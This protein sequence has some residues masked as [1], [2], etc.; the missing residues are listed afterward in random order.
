MQKNF[1]AAFAILALA[2]SPCLAQSVPETR[3]VSKVEAEALVRTALPEKLKRLPKFG[4]EISQ[5][6]N[7][8]RFYTALVYWEGEPNGSVM[9]GNYDIDQETGDVWDA[10]T[11]CDE[12]NTRALRRLQKTIRKEIGLSDSEFKS[13]KSKG[14]LCE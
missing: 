5:D 6:K 7:F 9:V 2:I 14:P 10:V 12:M 4:M 11:S 8:A 3:T 13:V 1:S